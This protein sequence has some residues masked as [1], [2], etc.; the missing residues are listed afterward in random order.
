MLKFIKL[1]KKAFNFVCCDLETTGLNSLEDTV[2]FLGLTFSNLEKNIFHNYVI[3]IHEYQ[4]ISGNTIFNKNNLGNVIFDFIYKQGIKTIGGAN[5][6]FDLK[7]LYGLGFP[8]YNN[9]MIFDIL[10]IEYLLDNEKYGKKAMLSLEDL[11]SDYY[12]EAVEYKKI[13]IKKKDINKDSIL[14]N[15]DYWEIR[16]ANDIYY[17]A[18]IVQSLYKKIREKENLKLWKIYKYIYSDLTQ[19]LA[20]MEYRGVKIDVKELLRL[21]ADYEKKIKSLVLK[22]KKIIYKD[23]KNLVYT[24]S[25]NIDSPAQMKV[26]FFERWKLPILS[27]T[28]K[29]SPQLRKDDYAKYLY[30]HNTGK[31]NL[32]YIVVKFL[33]LLKEYKLTKH[34]YS[35]FIVGILKNLD[36]QG[37]IHTEYRMTGTDTGRLSSANINLQNIPRDTTDAFIKMLFTVTNKHYKLL[38]MDLSQIELRVMAI[39]ANVSKLIEAYE[40]KQDIHLKTAAGMKDDS[41]EKAM[42]QYKEN[43]DSWKQIRF[44]AKKVN[45]GIQYCMEA[46]TLA[47]ALSDFEAGRVVSE[48]EAQAYI[49][50]YFKTYPEVKQYMTDQEIFVTENG[51]VQNLFGRKRHL[52]NIYSANSYIRESVIRQAVNTPIQSTAGDIMFL[53][54]VLI[55]K[56]AAKHNVKTH[57]LLTVYDSLLAESKTPKKV[58][59][60]YK[61]ALKK[62]IQVSKEIFGVEYSVPIE[63]SLD[64]GTHWGKHE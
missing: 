21:K 44:D 10:L 35:L 30:K 28:K 36:K 6:K 40:K 51:F 47:V 39:I 8:K 19:I 53:F 45:F 24:K 43:P 33:N 14:A 50:S 63:Y 54:I 27:K 29:G 34:R 55:Y 38:D 5:F 52:S 58:E 25:I 12:P 31:I 11:L 23:T 32:S 2:V 26:L 9:F 22:I 17:T 41:Y 59:K 15:K 61:L 18:K 20:Q 37:R 1:H 57:F 60:I 4:N 49:D 62:L 56:L 3:D 64:T 48:K 46:R 16:N 42:R 13:K 7:F